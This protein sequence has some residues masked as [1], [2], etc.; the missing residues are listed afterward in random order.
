MNDKTYGLTMWVLGFVAG[1][2]F[3]FILIMLLWTLIN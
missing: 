1:T 2:M 3:G